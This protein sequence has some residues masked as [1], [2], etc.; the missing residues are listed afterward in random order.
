M[1]WTQLWHA[2]SFP[3]WVEGNDATPRMHRVMIG[4][5]RAGAVVVAR[6]D[7][8]A[9]A[10]VRQR[11]L[12]IERDLW[13][14]PRG[15]SEESDADGIATGL[16]EL[17]EETGF[18]GENGISLG[19]IY[20]DSGILGGHIEV[21]ACTVPEQKRCEIDGEVDALQ[22]VSLAELRSMIVSG[23][24]QDSICRQCSRAELGEEVG[25]GRVFQEDSTA[26]R[27]RVSQVLNRRNTGHSGVLSTAESQ[28]KLADIEDR[29]IFVDGKG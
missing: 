8:G 13:E 11:R 16:R 24:L 12:A 5:D 14:F 15:M 10:L 9:L 23:E 26:R 2:Q 18:H 6:N 20:P 29:R 17:L 28:N 22:W 1:Q 19:Q 3:L 21:I 7:Q 4:G 27:G 25:G